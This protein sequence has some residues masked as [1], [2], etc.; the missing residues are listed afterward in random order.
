MLYYTKGAQG[1]EQVRYKGYWEHGLKGIH[2]T[3]KVLWAVLGKRIPVQICNTRIDITT[4]PILGLPILGNGLALTAG[5]TK[6]YPN[7]EVSHT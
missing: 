5:R 2:T 7:R 1:D 3:Q 6:H 4:Y